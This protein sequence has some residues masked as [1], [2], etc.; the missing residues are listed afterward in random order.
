M[1]QVLQHIPGT[2]CYLDDTIVTGKN[3]E[4]HLE[5]LHKVLS[6][7]SEYG[8]CAKKSKC[9]FFR[10]EISYCGYVIDKHGLH[11]SQEKI[12]A[13]LQAPK[14]KNVSQ[15]KSY[16]GLINY[17][18]KFLSNLAMLLHPLNALQKDRTKWEWSEECDKAFS[19]TKRW[20]TSDEVLTHHDPKRPIRLAC[21][22]SP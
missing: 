16:L 14:P 19:E 8:L 5:N 21:D 1:D 15:L 3:D 18:H 4:E 9:E 7:L 2:Q 6:R 11:K 20:I 13:V 10:S 22:A 12:E 17:Y